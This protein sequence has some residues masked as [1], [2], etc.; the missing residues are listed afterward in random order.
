[1]DSTS[2]IN[3]IGDAL[4]GSLLQPNEFANIEKSERL[5]SV[6][7]GAFIGLKGITN[8]FSNPLL[9][10]IEM[11]IGGALL[12]R[13]ITGYCPVKDM[14]S[15]SSSSLRIVEG[16]DTPSASEV[17]DRIDPEVAY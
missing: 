15:E 16:M 6:G 11:G 3:Q 7:A 4:E 8:V 1:M 14:V 2:M 12:Y 10:I 5:V 9:A 17:N 13:G